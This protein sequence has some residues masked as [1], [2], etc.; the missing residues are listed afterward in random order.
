MVMGVVS[1]ATA[2]L[3]RWVDRAGVVHYT[4]ELDS[5]PEAYRGSVETLEHPSARTAEP[6]A[7]PAPSPGA[8]PTPP[9]PAAAPAPSAAPAPGI[10]PVAIR[11]P[12]GAPVMVDAL[13]NGVQL[14][15]LV[16]TGADRTV[17]SPAA[18]G[19]AGYDPARGTPVRITGVTGSSTAMLVA[20]PQLDVSGA[21][22]GP[23][24]VIAHAVPGEGVDGLL[25]R[26]VLD[27]FTVTFDA[28]GNRATL[29]PRRAE[30]Q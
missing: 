25:G 21:Q 12:T 24:S 22:V 9:A 29:S 20:V 2:A 14:R 18:L 11:L 19:R 8:P 4:S 17:I 1:P 16:D 15:L 27:A 13:L 7:A 6:S 5:I 10:P 3:Y 30:S 26:D 23:L 28:T